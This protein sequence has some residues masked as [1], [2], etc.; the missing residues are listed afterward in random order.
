MGPTTAGVAGKRR[1]IS[2]IATF[3]AI[4][5]QNSQSCAACH[6]YPVCDSRPHEIK[7]MHAKVCIHCDALDELT[8]RLAW[9][10]GVQIKRGW[11]V[12]LATHAANNVLSW[13]KGRTF[14][15]GLPGKPLSCLANGFCRKSFVPNELFLW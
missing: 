2:K 7:A 8:N 11:S 9:P 4:R 10:R 5:R 14:S 6:V 12:V 15:S 13:A 1:C 3:D